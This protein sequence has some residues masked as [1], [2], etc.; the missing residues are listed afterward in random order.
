MGSG[1]VYGLRGVRSRRAALG[2]ERGNSLIMMLLLFPLIMGSFGLSFDLMAYLWIRGSVE[3]DVQQAVAAAATTAVTNTS[4]K[5]RVPVGEVAEVA[6]LGYNLNRSALLKCYGG[7]GAC[8]EETDPIS[9]EFEDNGATVK[10]SWGIQEYYDPF[11]LG[12]L[13]VDEL[14]ITAFSDARLTT[15]TVPLK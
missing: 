8:W 7:S 15:T 1:S 9:V 4:G 11:F 12:F 2:R 14:S 13:G 6:E 5:L 3:R 10:V